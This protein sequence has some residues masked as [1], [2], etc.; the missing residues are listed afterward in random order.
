MFSFSSSH[1]KYLSSSPAYFL[2][3]FL[4]FFAKMVVS[5]QELFDGCDNLSSKVGC[6]DGLVK[7]SNH[8]DQDE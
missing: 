2:F 5:R 1:V 4:Y 3:S 7:V 6:A 8:P